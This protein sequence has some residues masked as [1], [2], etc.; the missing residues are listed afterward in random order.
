M[1]VGAELARPPWQGCPR[2]RTKFQT[3]VGF[4]L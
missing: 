3:S 1:V 4:R 2:Y